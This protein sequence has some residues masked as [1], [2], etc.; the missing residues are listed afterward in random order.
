MSPVHGTAFDIAGEGVAASDNL[1]ATIRS[2]AALCARRADF[3][4][5]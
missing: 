4:L 2:A 3:A 1:V 5:G